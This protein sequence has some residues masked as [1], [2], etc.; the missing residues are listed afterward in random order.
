MNEKSNVNLLPAG[1]IEKYYQN[2]EQ[3]ISKLQEENE[4]LTADLNDARKELHVLK[5]YKKIDVDNAS[6]GFF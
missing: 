3:L 2:R 4:A 5:N 1:E 6:N